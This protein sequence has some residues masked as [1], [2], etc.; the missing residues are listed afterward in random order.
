[1]PVVSVI[2]PTYNR[3]SFLDEAIE[4]VLGQDFQDF[5]LIVVD[6]SSTDSTSHLLSRYGS[7]LT[8]LSQ[9]HRGVSAARNLGIR[10]ARGKYIAFLDSDD[11]W[12]PQK[13]SRQI[14]FF[15][16]TPEVWICQTDEHWI[17]KGRRVNPK[18]IHKKYSGWIFE[19]CLPLCLVSPSAVAMRKDLFREVGFFDESLPVCEDYDLWLRVSQRYPVFLL[20]EKL[21]VKRGGHDDQ[22]SRKSW[23]NDRYR[24]A[25]L[26]KIVKH[27]D[28]TAE[29]RKAVL[30]ELS[31]KA[32]ILSRGFAKRGKTLE[33]EM[34]QK[35][36][37]VY[38][39]EKENICRIHVNLI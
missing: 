20:P 1:M 3:A 26:E 18:R 33:A 16:E 7:R 30:E 14:S 27:P 4:S 38:Q 29:Q 9:S 28:L 13:L 8:R 19:K 37:S 2:I 31:R 10:S 17:R 23:G 32:S 35:R 24:I 12:L 11:Y 6:D 5:E 39:A 25:A 34:Y 22:L 21:V 15:Q 36:L